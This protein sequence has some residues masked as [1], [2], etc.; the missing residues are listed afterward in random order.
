LEARCD[1]LSVTVKVLDDWFVC[2]MQIIFQTSDRKFNMRN[3]LDT[4]VNIGKQEGT[5]GL[6]RGNMAT[7]LRVFPWAQAPHGS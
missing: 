2:L 4:L 3:V 7:V 6:W 1:C 5:R